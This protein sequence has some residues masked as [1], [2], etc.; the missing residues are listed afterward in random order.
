[1]ETLS[2]KEFVDTLHLKIYKTYSI[3]VIEDFILEN[4]LIKYFNKN[5]NN[6]YGKWIV[7]KDDTILFSFYNQ[8]FKDRYIENY[9]MI[10]IHG[11]KKYSETDTIKNYFYLELLKKLNDTNQQYYLQRLDYAIDINKKAEHIFLYKHSKGSK[12]NTLKD[13]DFTSTSKGNYRLE[14]DNKKFNSNRLN[15]LTMYDKKLKENLDETVTRVE[16]SLL[17]NSFREIRK[18]DDNNFFTTIQ[19]EIQKYKIYYFE[20][21][22]KREEC[23]EYYDGKNYSIS[24]RV[25]SKL[26]KKYLVHSQKLKFDFK[27]LEDFFCHF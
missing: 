2:F 1:M 14:V 22:V 20:D 19:N 23:I 8:T 13:F 18:K 7:K 26:D 11:L 21:K 25:I 3:K 6:N 17:P 5:Q 15:R 27:S 24:E 12:F 4:N 10:E 16:I 9:V